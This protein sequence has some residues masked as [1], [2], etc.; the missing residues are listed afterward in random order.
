VTTYLDILGVCCL[1]L[2]AFSIWPPLCL[3]V[4]GVAALLASWVA[5]RA[6][7]KQGDQ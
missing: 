3:G 6:K 7:P 2:L 4:I 1:S 5:E